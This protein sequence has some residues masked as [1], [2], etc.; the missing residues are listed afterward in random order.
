MMKLKNVRVITLL[1]ILLKYLS[2]NPPRVLKLLF[3]R[4][5]T[6]HLYIDTVIE[7]P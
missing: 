1:F 6:E 5:E 2:V 3:E 7:M 4:K